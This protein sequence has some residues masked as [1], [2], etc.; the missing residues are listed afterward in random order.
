MTPAEFQ[1]LSGV[2]VA[3]GFLALVHQMFWQVRIGLIDRQA[4][5]AFLFLLITAAIMVQLAASYMGGPRLG[6]TD[7]G[8]MFFFLWVGS[9]IWWSFCTLHHNAVA[10]RKMREARKQHKDVSDKLR[11]PL[12]GFRE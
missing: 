3:L 11:R 7:R 8:V 4:R 2:L 10:L 9:L 1:T 6:N 12:G 5:S